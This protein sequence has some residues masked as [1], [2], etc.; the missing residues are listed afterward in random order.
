MKEFIILMLF[1]FWWRLF[2]SDLKKIFLKEKYDLIPVLNKD[3]KIKKI[4]FFDDLF[5]QITLKINPIK[6]VIMAGGEGVRLRPC[7]LYSAKTSIA[8]KQ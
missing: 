2:I 8:C 1:Q 5:K 7:H 4:I 6:T 3:K